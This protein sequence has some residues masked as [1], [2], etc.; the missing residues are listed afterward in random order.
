VLAHEKAHLPVRFDAGCRRELLQPRCNICRLPAFRKGEEV[1]RLASNLALLVTLATA[2]LAAAQEPPRPE[3]SAVGT[4]SPVAKS[5]F[6]SGAGTPAPLPA[7]RLSAE[8][9]PLV[10]PAFASPSLVRRF[11]VRA[12]GG[13]STKSDVQSYGLSSYLGLRPP[14]RLDRWLRGLGLEGLWLIE[15]SAAYLR[16]EKEPFTT[17]SFELGINPVFVRLLFLRGGPV[18]PYLEAGEG[19]VYIDLRGQDLG[20]RLQFASQA[21]AGVEVQ[22]GERFS[23]DVGYRYRHLSNLG[24]ASN[25][26]INTHLGLVGLA[27]RLP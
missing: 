18:L 6:L 16:D 2:A 4:Q 19:I 25:P 9:G 17:E 20:T 21:A 23:L 15:G 7:F 1:T 26:G 22:L 13:I 3:H 8:P 24:M 5:G 10:A 12:M 14:F 27:Y 11:A